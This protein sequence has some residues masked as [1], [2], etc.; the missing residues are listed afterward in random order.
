M[1]VSRIYA[2]LLRL[3]PKAYQESFAGEMSSVFQRLAREYGSDSALGRMRFVMREVTGLL[4]GA[5]GAWLARAADPR[6]YSAAESA[7]PTE[8]AATQARINVL[9]DRAVHAIATHD[10]ETARTCAYEERQQRDKLRSL[11]GKERAP[12]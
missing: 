1:V 2:G 5:A 12:E 10:F 11:Q 6:R 9:V 8:I 3:Y 4:A 7:A